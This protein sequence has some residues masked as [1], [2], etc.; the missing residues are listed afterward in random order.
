MSDFES[1]TVELQST[2]GANN[3]SL[4]Q[5]A[6]ASIS[7]L[8]LVDCS[9]TL[10]PQFIPGGTVWVRQGPGNEHSILLIAQN[11]PDPRTFGEDLTDY[12]YV[13][14]GVIQR[15][16][17]RLDDTNIW[18]ASHSGTDLALPFPPLAPVY[19]VAGTEGEPAPVLRILDSNLRDCH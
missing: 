19:I 2:L 3:L 6:L 17:G 14:E 7:L 1:R 12:W 10:R 16:I 11:L 18:F 4:P 8:A 15:R 13:I 5:G 9:V